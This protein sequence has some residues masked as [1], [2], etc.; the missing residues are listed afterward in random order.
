MTKD[1]EGGGKELIAPR[2]Q[3]HNARQSAGREGE[4]LK[5]S[6]KHRG[7]IS[8]LFGSDGSSFPGA[9]LS[10]PLQLLLSAGSGLILKLR[11]GPMD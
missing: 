1:K 3:L 9:V 6:G 5:P 2:L 8:K 10:A 4:L 11:N 7:T